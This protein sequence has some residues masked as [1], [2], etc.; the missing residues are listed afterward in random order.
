MN[1]APLGFAEAKHQAAVEHINNKEQRIMRDIVGP[2][3]ICNST[4]YVCWR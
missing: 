3:N 4:E 2:W 1:A